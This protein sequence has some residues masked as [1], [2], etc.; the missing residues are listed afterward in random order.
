M[1]KTSNQ[2]TSQREQ[3][4]YQRAFFQDI[5]KHRELGEKRRQ[6]NNN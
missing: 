1:D 3:K 4:T 2:P 5:K 6:N